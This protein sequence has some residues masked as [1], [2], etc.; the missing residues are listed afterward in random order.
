MTTSIDTIRRLEEWQSKSK[1]HSVRIEID[2]GYGATC[3]TV[4]LRR[5][6]SQIQA[7]ES[8]GESCRV[9]LG[10]NVTLLVGGEGDWP[11]LE[12][13]INAAID[14]AEELWK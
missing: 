14:A 12:A 6:V 8:T 3:W 10:G 4:T 1:S 11:G 2:D 7:Q 9:M 5:G 13:T